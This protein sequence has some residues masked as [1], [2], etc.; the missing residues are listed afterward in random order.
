MGINKI[1]LNTEDGEEVLINLTGDKVTEDTLF[2]GVTAHNSNGEQITGTFP[3]GEVDE[4]SN[5][6]KL[7]KTTLAGKIAPSGGSG[8]G[9]GIIDVT[10]LPKSDIDENAMYRVT[11]TIKLSDTEIY[12]NSGANIVT[13]RQYLASMGVPTAPNM[14]VVDELPSDM[15]VTDVQTF[16]EV[17]CYILRS[18][19]IAYINAPVVGGVMTIGMMAYQST[20]YDKGLVKNEIEIRV[21]NDAGVYTTIETYKD[22]VRYYIRQNDEW[23]EISAYVEYTNY[24]GDGE[25]EDEKVTDI[26]VLS[27]D[28]TSR[29]LGAGDI[30]SGDI[31]ELKEYHFLRRNGTYAIKI[32]D[33]A[34][35]LTDLRSATIPKDV[36][37]IEVGAFHTCN[38]LQTVTF[39]G[40]P[41][42]IDPTAFYGCNNDLVF[43]VPWAEDDSIN[44]YQPWGA[45][46][47]TIRYNQTG[48]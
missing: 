24:M 14:Y 20:D 29:V 13:L 43:R 7:I 1:T 34:F 12:F 40:R 21:H 23:K 32:K 41:L 42:H 4:Q 17:H 45:T 39:K 37:R 35:A 10:E 16:S 38:Y 26:E 48:G 28:I 30:V 15:N 2:D 19:G 27:G 25:H 44:Q 5:L 36:E 31:E 46:R 6:I 3:I 8:G 11:E 9:S 22:V 18:N 33:Y 47:A